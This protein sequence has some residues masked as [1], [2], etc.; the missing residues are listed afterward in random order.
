MSPTVIPSAFPPSRSHTPSPAPL[1]EVIEGRGRSLVPGVSRSMSSTRRGGRSP[2]SCAELPSEGNPGSSGRADRSQ[3]RP[4]EPCA[5]PGRCA[6]TSFDLTLTAVLL[7]H[8]DAGSVLKDARDGRHFRRPR[9]PAAGSRGR[10][11]ETTSLPAPARFR[12]AR[13]ASSPTAAPACRLSLVQT[14]DD[15][16]HGVRAR[17]E[18]AQPIALAD[19]G[20]THA[21]T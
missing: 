2:R 14:L 4:A 3:A 17:R 10:P 6:R 8:R 16:Q 13:R 7:D 12:S 15:R 11:T 19:R 9:S 5:G 1:I 21:P 20:I 18:S